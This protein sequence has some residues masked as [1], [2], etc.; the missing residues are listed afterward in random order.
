[1]TD[2]H[3][4][5]IAKEPRAGHVKTRLCP[6]CTPD[7][8]C[9]IASAALTDTLDG[10]D[11]LAAASPIAFERV[12]LFDGDPSSCLRPGWRTVLQRGDGL[13]DRL[14]NG[15]ADLGPGVIVGMETP[16]VTA[17]LGAALEAISRGHDA[18]G[19]AA[20]GGYWAIGLHRTD[21][22]V[23]I[24]VPM[25]VSNTGLAQLRRMHALGRSVER[26]PAARDL[27]TF[28]DL[29]DAASRRASS[30]RL[31][32]IAT[33]VTSRVLAAEARCEATGEASDEH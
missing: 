1:M 17:A 10:I 19:L 4:S 14:T 20:D 3:V 16:H 2:M 5:V 29:V 26:L 23:F 32:T 22:R 25:S 7:E 30:V 18:I 21:P 15:F 13:A 27:D 8:A 31:R 11:R 12:L 28:D 33:V 6:P 9:A 24:D